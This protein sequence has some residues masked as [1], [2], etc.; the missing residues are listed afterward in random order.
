MKFITCNKKINFSFTTQGHIFCFLVVFF[1][2]L[3]EWDYYNF[4]T[5]FD[6]I[7]RES[8]MIFLHNVF[9][10]VMYVVPTYLVNNSSSSFMLGEATP[11]HERLQNI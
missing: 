8:F 1:F 9:F 11:Q 4:F 10:N 5:T 2:T 7:L 6:F 3:F